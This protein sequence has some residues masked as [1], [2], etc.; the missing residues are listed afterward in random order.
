M[1]EIKKPTME[2]KFDA[3]SAGRRSRNGVSWTGRARVRFDG[4]AWSTPFAVSEEG[5]GGALRT[6]EVMPATQALLVAYDEAHGVEAHSLMLWEAWEVFDAQRRWPAGTWAVACEG[7]V[8]GARD[9]ATARD[10][11]GKNPGSHVYAPSKF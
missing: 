4:G 5:N 1:V 11:A 7:A 3:A 6:V 8:E 2:A 9:E 10:L